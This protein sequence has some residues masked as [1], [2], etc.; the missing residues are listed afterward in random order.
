MTA[1]LFF[2]TN[3]LVYAVDPQTRPK[4][5]RAADLIR[6][7]IGRGEFVVSPQT[8]NECYRV[9]TD[10]RRVVAKDAARRFVTEFMPFCSAP[11]DATTTGLAFEVQD[12]LGASWFDCTMVASALQARCRAFLTEDL[13]HGR[14]LGGLTIVHPFETPIEQILH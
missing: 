12:V 6:R 8:L 2:D 14:T 7:A 5:D 10:K 9:L 4:R 1:R 11:L 13:Q 3:V